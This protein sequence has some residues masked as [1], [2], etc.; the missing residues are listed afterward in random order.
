[1][2]ARRR[3]RRW[4]WMIP[5]VP[6]ALILI[7]LGGATIKYGWSTVEQGMLLA[8]TFLH[9]YQPSNAS[10]TFIGPWTHLP[11]PG[12]TIGRLV[13]PALHVDLPI[14]Q[15]TY[16]NQRTEVGHFAGSTLPGEGGNV[17]LETSSPA[18]QKLGKLS[19]GTL[20]EFKA[21]QGVFSYQVIL[22]S[23]ISSIADLSSDQG[24]SLTLVETASRQ[25]SSSPLLSARAKPLFPSQ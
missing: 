4:P 16:A 18:L 20:I 2:R 11:E 24:E 10:N 14:V 22:I 19:D 1:M 13:I 23:K 5:A 21:P 7:A 15:G 3:R 12:G 8:V 25:P 6:A 17:I 9:P